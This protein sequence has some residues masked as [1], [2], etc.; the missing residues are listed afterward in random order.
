MKKETNA[1]KEKSSFIL[2]IYEWA[3]TFLVAL[4]T[5]VL[6]FTFLVKFVTVSGMSMLQTFNDRDRL[7]ITS[8]TSY[9]AGDVVVIDPTHNLEEMGL[10]NENSSSPYIKRIIATEGQSVNIDPF[11]WSVYV[12][13]V[14][15]DE[16]YVYHCNL[17]P[18]YRGSI[19]YPYVVPKG[20][21]FVMGDNRNGSS[22]SRQFG[23]IDT[24]YILGEV[25]FRLMPNTEVIN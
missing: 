11:T 6:I 7:L 12:D 2:E 24:D 10:V 9:K 18:M 20:H 21:V 15:L 22:D 19:T 5:V 17:N 14:K 13:G 16:P 4:L 3:E 25:F 1:T 8:L 23:A